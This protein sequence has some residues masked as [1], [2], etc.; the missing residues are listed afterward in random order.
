[1]TPANPTTIQEAMA[2]LRRR[3]FDPVL[4]CG[5]DQEGRKVGNVP[6]GYLDIFTDME[7]PKPAPMAGYRGTRGRT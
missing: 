5:A 3:G 4:V 1:M 7:P 2:D 6:D